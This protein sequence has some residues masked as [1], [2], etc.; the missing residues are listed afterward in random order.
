VWGEGAF[1][2]ARSA[3]PHPSRIGGRGGSFLVLAFTI[4]AEKHDRYAETRMAVGIAP[5]HDG[6][7]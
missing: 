1:F 4:S 5:L 3:S 7:A 6:G 2:D